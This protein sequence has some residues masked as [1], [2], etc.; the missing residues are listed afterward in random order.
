MALSAFGCGFQVR[1]TMNVP[2]EMQRTY[3]AASDQHSRFYQRL[4]SELREFGVEIVD[5]PAEATAVLSIIDDITDQRVLS[6]SA[7]N[8][9]REYEVYYTITYSLIA[10]Q[11]TV[12]EPRTQ[13]Q[14]RAYTWDEK[15]VLGKNR[16]EQ[17]LREALVEDLVRIVLIQISAT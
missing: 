15:R 9:P 4:R 5:S 14:T 3:I 6:V 16:E 2:P 12:I 8:V 7:R 13:T 11:E 17:V 10:D 1:G